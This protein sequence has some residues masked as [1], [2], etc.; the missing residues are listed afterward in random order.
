MHR[1]IGFR[2][3]IPIRRQLRRNLTA[4]EKV[5]WEQIANRQFQDLKFVKQ[6]GI[7]PY[8]VD[9]CCRALMLIIEIDGDSH[10]TNFGISQDKVRTGYLENL[11]YKIIRYNN[12]DVINNLDGVFQDLKSKT[13]LLLISSLKGGEITA[14]ES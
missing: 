5:F 1:T 11:G 14:R 7:G 4:P 12:H 10:A 6:H 2:K 9:F 3:T 13:D 8:I